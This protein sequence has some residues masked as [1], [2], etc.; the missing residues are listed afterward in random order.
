LKLNTPS[1]SPDRLISHPIG[2]P[3][4]RSA[5]SAPRIAIPIAVTIPMA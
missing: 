3:G 2:F 1:S 5:I 4:F